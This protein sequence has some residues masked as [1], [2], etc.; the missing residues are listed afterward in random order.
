MEQKNTRNATLLQTTLALALVLGLSNCSSQKETL[1]SNGIEQIRSGQL[2]K[3]INSFSQLLAQNPADASAHFGLGWAYQNKGM[4]DPA[5]QQYTLAISSAVET[6]AFSY[7]NLGV[8]FQAKKKFAEAIGAYQ[9]VLSI[10]PKNADASY[11]LAFVYFDQ[12]L[13]HIALN[14]FL[15]T[16]KRK[17]THAWAH[18]HAGNISLK[19]GKK[20]DA[21]KY[22]K[23]AIELDGSIKEAVEKLKALGG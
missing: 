1:Y 5:T 8:L 12:G 16:I 18:Y 17:P 2:D 4:A 15:D 19:L 6:L 9:R 11:N 23:K 13:D 20:E 7:F 3:A 21:K 10:Q 14:Q 22:L